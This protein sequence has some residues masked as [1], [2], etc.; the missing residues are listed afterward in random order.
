MRFTEWSKKKQDE[1]QEATMGFDMKMASIDRLRM[2]HKEQA[3]LVDQLEKIVEK[4]YA[5]EVAVISKQKYTRTRE[6]AFD[7]TTSYNA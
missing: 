6:E 5:G 2:L 4:S 1:I 7:G 3:K